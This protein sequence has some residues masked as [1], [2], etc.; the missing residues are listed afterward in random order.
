MEVGFVGLGIM[1]RPMALNLIRGGHSLRVWAR[2]AESMQP[3]VEA[4]ALACASAADAARGAQVVFSMVADAPD[5]AEVALGVGGVADGAAPGSIFI[6]MSTIAPAAARDIAGRLSERGIDMLDA[7]VSGG[8]AGAINGA[9]TIMV[10]GKAAAF[11]RVRP[12]F[13]CLGKSITLIG[14]SGAGQVA[15]AC[16]QVV[17]G[18]SVAVIAEAFNFARIN[19]V[20]V[21][22][23][24]EAL[25]GGFA[26]SRILDNHGGRMLARNFRPGFKAWMHQKDLRIVLDEAHSLGIALPTAAVTAQL[27]NAMSGS[28]LGEDDSVGVL[29]LYER[30]SGGEAQ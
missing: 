22:R 2:R 14:E 16:N 28:G 12:L 4:G 11:E 23:V 21:G 13:E 19:G 7:P 9:L 29:K 24:R 27:F 1:G 6:D 8:E 26:A 25:L 20:D 18:V 15:K 30:L 5:V 10:G 3:L 17:T